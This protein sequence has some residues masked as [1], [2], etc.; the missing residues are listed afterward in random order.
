MENAVTE[1]NAYLNKTEKQIINIP[2]IYEQFAFA[3]GCVHVV[4]FFN[5]TNGYFR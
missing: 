4:G 3:N 2:N 5:A 1:V